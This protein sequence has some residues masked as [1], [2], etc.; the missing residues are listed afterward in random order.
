MPRSAAD[1]IF[2]VT[3]PSFGRLP[4]V[5]PAYLVFGE[6]S[7]LKLSECCLP[8][9]VDPWVISS[10]CHTSSQKLIAQKQNLGMKISLIGPS[11]A[12]LSGKDNGGK[13]RL[14][15]SRKERLSSRGLVRP[16]E[17]VG[18]LSKCF[19]YWDVAHFPNF[20]FNPIC[21]L[22]NKSSKP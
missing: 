20:Y 19:D 9:G 18:R 15:W 12:H 8:R 21:G 2:N 11:Y 16:W 14:N 4:N 5:T 3:L 1:Y 10:S 17:K 13:K 6:Y 7:S 22:R